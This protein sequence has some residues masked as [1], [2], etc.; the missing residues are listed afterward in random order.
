MMTSAEDALETALAKQLNEYIARDLAQYG[1]SVT[2]GYLSPFEFSQLAAESEVLWR[3]GAFR[4]AGVGQGQKLQ[5][6]PE[7]RSDRVLWLESTAA[8]AAQTRYLSA[9]DNLRLV[10]NRT[11]FVGLF[12]FEGHL[13]VYP[14]GSYYREHLD[15]FQGVGL[16]TVTT[17]LYL[18]RNWQPEDGGQLRIYT[19]P[20]DPE[21]YEELLPLGGRLVTFLSARFLHEVLPARRE[22]FSI[23]GWFKKRDGLF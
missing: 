17:I 14:P 13:A 3:T 23:T 21:H 19:D 20:N 16:R 6:R 7:V 5:I 2:D 9:L 8:S 12:E 10:I 4:K 1:W 15:Q 11:L 18:N 22:Q